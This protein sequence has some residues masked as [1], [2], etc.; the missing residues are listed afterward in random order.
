MTKCPKPEYK[1]D[2]SKNLNYLAFYG[3]AYVPNGFVAD[4]MYVANYFYSLEDSASKKQNCEIL[5]TIFQNYLKASPRYTPEVTY[6]D[7]ESFP[8]SSYDVSIQKEVP[9]AI[10]TKINQMKT[11][12]EEMRE[13][14]SQED[15][16]Q[17]SSVKEICDKMDE[18]IL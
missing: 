9:L 11:K 15:E 13:N 16:T 1:K 7:E 14:K 8:T 10:Q 12:I 6:P 5:D 4:F 3:F 18:F 2:M 17:D